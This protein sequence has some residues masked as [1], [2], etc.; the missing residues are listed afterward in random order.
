MTDCRNVTGGICASLPMCKAQPMLQADTKIR[1][2]WKHTQEYSQ[3]RR[4]KTALLACLLLPLS[5]SPALEKRII[6]LP[7]CVKVAVLYPCGQGGSA[8]LQL[9][10][11]LSHQVWLCCPPKTHPTSVPLP[12]ARQHLEWSWECKG[13]GRWTKF[14]RWA[15]APVAGQ[16]G[17][18]SE[19]AG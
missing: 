2:L 7:D 12:T 19:L 13:R 14:H 9:L 16:A 11:A 1:L 4:G 15:L 5:R 18:L 6:A 3:N 8:G 10:S 17:Q